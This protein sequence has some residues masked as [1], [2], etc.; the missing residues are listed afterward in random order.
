MTWI[1]MLGYLLAPFLRFHWPAVFRLVKWSKCLE[2]KHAQFEQLRP[3]DF[4]SPNFQEFRERPAKLMYDLFTYLPTIGRELVKSIWR[5]PDAVVHSL[6]EFAREPNYTRF[7][8]FAMTVISQVSPKHEFPSLTNHIPT[9]LFD[10]ASL[11]RWLR[12]NLERTRVPNDFRA[13][14][15]KRGRQLY[16]T[17]CDLDTAERVSFWA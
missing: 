10:N 8:A 7:E 5:L 11:E 3:F 4:Y 13:F 14:S 9:G 12:R 17:A 2:G 6:Q 15:R 16:I 1:F